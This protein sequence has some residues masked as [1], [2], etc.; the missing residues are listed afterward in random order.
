M[1]FSVLL[2]LIITTSLFSQTSLDRGKE[3]L[4]QGKYRE[5]IGQL[6][7]VLD[8]YPRNAEAWRMLGE[9]YLRV[10]NLD[11]AEIAARRALSIDDERP[12][13][14]M[15]LSDVLAGRKNH[16]EAISTLRRAMK[17]KAATSP[18]LTHLGFLLLSLDSLDQAIVAFSQAKEANPNYGL[19]YEGLGDAY[20]KQGVPAIAILQYEKG[21]EVDS[22]RPSIYYKLAN[23]YFKERRY[24]DAARAYR[25]VLRIDST[26]CNAQLELG[27]LYFAAKLYPDAVNVLKLYIKNCSAK[28]EVLLMNTEAL[29]FSRQYEEALAM[30]ENQLKSDPKSVR[31][32]RVVANSYTEL[33]KHDKAIQTFETL[34]KLDTLRFEDYRHLARS[35]KETK[36]DSLAILTLERAIALDST[37]LQLYS[38]LGGIFMNLRQW[39]KAA[40]AFEKRFQKET[41]PGRAV[42]AYVNYGRCMMAL[43]DWEMGRWALRTALG[44][45]PQYIQGYGWLGL[46]LSQ[47][48]SLDEAKKAYITVLAMIDTVSDKSEYKTEITDAHQQIGFINLRQKKY[49]EAIESLVRADKLRPND[50]Q[51]LLWIAQSYHFLRKDEEACQY[52][53]RV[54][55]LD[56]KN[57]AAKKGVD[58]LVCG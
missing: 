9:A 15:T 18:L 50:V 46:C 44:I 30:A 14:Y 8:S 54:L 34:A 29:Y 36:R 55:K 2:S 28:G 35:Y 16:K 6:R 13:P 3:L 11:S 51:T 27:K 22:L 57:E 5:A 20:M 7:Q 24:T 31:A 1:K 56:S 43:Q 39:A 40:A 58:L 32:T 12:E 45:Y 25:N 19:A 49:Q 38:D 21:V 52:Y 41:V 42:G 23:A 4:Q 48:D 47:L 17:N 26:N 37:E 53:K 10:G 33:K